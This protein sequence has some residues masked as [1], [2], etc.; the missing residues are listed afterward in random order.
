MLDY[1]SECIS[2]LLEANMSAAA[3]VISENARRNG[4]LS[5]LTAF[6]VCYIFNSGSG[7]AKPC[8]ELH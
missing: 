7:E 5:A 2:R 1:L 4:T 8:D 6:P 3:G